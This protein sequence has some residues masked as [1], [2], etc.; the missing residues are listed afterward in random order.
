MPYL[1]LENMN[2]KNDSQLKVRVQQ[3]LRAAALETAHQEGQTLS[4]V[5]RHYLECYVL[6]GARKAAK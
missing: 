4:A 3:Q 2:M 1:I 6:T 5:I